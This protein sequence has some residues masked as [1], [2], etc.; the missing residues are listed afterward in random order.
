MLARIFLVPFILFAAARDV[1]AQSVPAQAA[2]EPASRAPIDAIAPTQPITRVSKGNGELP[3]QDGQIWRE[4]DITP[5]TARVTSSPKPEQAIVDWILRETGTEMWFSLPLGIINA[6][7]NTLTV[8]HTADTQRLVS[9]IVDRFIVSQAESHVFALRLM[10]VGSPNWRSR[11]YSLLRPVSVQTPGVDAW[12]LSKENAAVLAVELAKRNDYRE[13]KS[14]NLAIQNGQT[15]TIARKRP[16][17][18]I[19][20]VRMG[21]TAWPGH[22]LEMTQIEEGFSLQLSPLLSLDQHTVDCVIK[23]EVDQIEKLV[24][25]VIDVPSPTATRQRVQIQIAQMASWR[26]HERFRWPIDQVLVISCG[27]GA[28]PGP[29]Q[30]TMLGVPNPFATSPPRA[31]ALLFIESKGKVSQTLESEAG[32]VANTINTRARY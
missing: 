16:R 6:G 2:S 24:P 26:L 32:E 3:H 18:Y 14:P 23:C 11:V 19:R 25:V 10:T 21:D 17:N 20:S 8:Y 4:Y 31:D 15:H 5:Y 12:L 7:P 22:E 1:A 29:E 13:Y 30:P 9:E 28:T 27:V